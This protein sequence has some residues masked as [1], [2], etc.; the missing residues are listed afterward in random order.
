MTDQGTT[1]LH[2]R[3]GQVKIGRP[4]QT[5]TA[6]LGSCV[7]IGFF[8]KSR[9]IYGL[10]HC[11]L[12]KS[13][14]ELRNDGSGRHVDEA[15]ASLLSMMDIQP[16]EHRQLRVVLAGGANMSMPLDTPPEQLVG[17]T[18]AKFARKTLRSAKLRLLDDDLGGTNG[19]RITIDCAT[20]EYEIMSIPRLQGAQP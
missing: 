14:G 4:G 19:R 13:A 10:A 7:G 5:L 9:D 15:I 16:D 1:E 8:L 17:T 6:I 20:G 2:V 12:S 3:I 18:N 11:L